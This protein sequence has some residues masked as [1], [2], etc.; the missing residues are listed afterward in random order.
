MTNSETVANRVVAPDID[1][2]KK[3]HTQATV[4]HLVNPTAAIKSEPGNS[5]VWC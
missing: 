3:G 2:E 4:E 1:V 5:S